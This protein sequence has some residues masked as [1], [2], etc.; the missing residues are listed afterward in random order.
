MFGPVALVFRSYSLQTGMEWSVSCLLFMR[1]IW[2]VEGLG[3]AGRETHGYPNR[4]LRRERASRSCARQKSARQWKSPFRN[5]LFPPASS[6]HFWCTWMCG[7]RKDAIFIKNWQWYKANVDVIAHKLFIIII[8]TL[9][10]KIF[11]STLMYLRI[12]LKWVYVKACRKPLWMICTTS[13]I[14]EVW[15]I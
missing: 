2:S 15:N 13:E 3:W 11:T 7:N 5:P 8:L 14:L 12:S 4:E 9:W 6:V 10:P 1:I